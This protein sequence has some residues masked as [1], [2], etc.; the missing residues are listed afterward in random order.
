M[1]QTWAI[2][3]DAYRELNAKKLFWVTMLISAL[4]VVA[5][6][7]VSLTPKGIK[8]IVWEF[9]WPLVNLTLLTNAAF[10]KFIFQAFGVKFWL[11]WAATIIG[12]IATCSMIPD[13]VA[14]G[15]IEL[16][17]SKPISRT[18]LFLS[19]FLAGLLF[20]I[21]QVSVFSVA[22]FLLIGI[23]GGEWNPRVLLAIP[24]VSLVFSY[25]FCVCA[26]VGL[27]TRSAIFSLIAT[28]L[29]WLLVFA[30]HAVE[31]GVMLQLRTAAE[32][33]VERTQARLERAEKGEPIEDPQPPRKKKNNGVIGTIVDAVTPKPKPPTVDE[34]RTELQHARDDLGTWE[35]W[36]KIFFVVKTVLP[37]TS[38]TA[39]LLQR[40]MFAKGELLS[41]EEQ[42]VDNQQQAEERMSQ[43][44]GRPTAR[45]Y[46]IGDPTVA[47]QATRRVQDRSVSWVIGTSLGFEGVVLAFACWRFVRRDF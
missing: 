40:W 18:R 13:F 33:N 12:L 35:R 1:R 2:F 7:T 24:I 45:A 21:L 22:V 4:V 3:V 5:F 9:P 15:S 23:R 47:Q 43:L 42:Q 37:K 32:M 36:H 39:D 44:R 38:E 8:V 27:I 10:Y 6:A 29:V 17:L 31:T 19:K 41:F 26:G 28:I 16:T 46:S 20:T 30:V 34:L 25:L 14:S 11:T